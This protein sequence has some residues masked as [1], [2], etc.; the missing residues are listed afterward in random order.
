MG[1]EETPIMKVLETIADRLVDMHLSNNRRFDDLAAQLE[2]QL[3]VN[4]SI[5]WHLKAIIQHLTG[6]RAALT[7]F[8]M[9]SEP[10][11][12]PNE[13]EAMPV[14]ED[15][16]TPWPVDTRPILACCPTCG[17]TAYTE[18]AVEHAFG[19]RTPADRETIRQ[20]WCRRCRALEQ[21]TSPRKKQRLP[22]SVTKFW[23]E[24]DL[25]RKQADAKRDERTECL[26]ST[27]GRETKQSLALLNQ[28][29]DLRI[30][31][32][33]LVAQY[34]SARRAFRRGEN[35]GTDET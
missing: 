7:A 28:E 21:A 31:V 6:D 14:T 32:R 9:N 18:G 23:R 24:A 8:A 26:K 4:A 19:Y 5:Q 2:A 17:M 3:T 29:H 34:D 10:T 15:D 12:V 13:D 22:D 11:V 35:G 30:Q 16:E 25:L 1:Y 33:K 20:S 27:N